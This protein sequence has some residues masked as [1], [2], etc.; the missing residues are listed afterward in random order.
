M[1]K[2]YRYLPL[3]FVLILVLAPIG[4]RAYL[5]RVLESEKQHFYVHFHAVVM[6]LWCII[7]IT[8]PLLLLKRKVHYHKLIGR[9]SY[10]FVPILVLSMLM[11]LFN[12]LIIAGRPKISVDGIQNIFFPFTQI[13]IFVI[14]YVLAICN[15]SRPKVHMRYIIVS[16][17]SLLGPTI[18]RIDFEALGLPNTDWD[19]W[20]MEGFLLLFLIWDARKLRSIKYYG[21]GLLSFLGVHMLLTFNFQQGAIWNSFG[22]HLSKVLV[23]IF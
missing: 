14:F 22:R 23:F 9:F 16:S 10:I 21:I 12:S 1:E 6:T 8:Q 7:L 2:G 3:L 13:L 17:I 15:R 20:V 4:F 18:G 19:L 11:M 5:Q